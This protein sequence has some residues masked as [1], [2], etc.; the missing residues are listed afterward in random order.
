ML[1]FVKVN[2]VAY[3][4][5]KYYTSL[6]KADHLC[7]CLQRKIFFLPNN[8]MVT[9]VDMNVSLTSVIWIDFIIYTLPKYASV[10]LYDTK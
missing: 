4:Q 6:S 3:N 2:S 1:R 9:S 10:R 8:T 5:L 7:N